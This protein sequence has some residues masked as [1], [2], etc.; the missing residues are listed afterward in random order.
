MQPQPYHFEVR[1]D[2]KTGTIKPWELW[3]VFDATGK[4]FA[5][6]GSFKTEAAAQKAADKANAARR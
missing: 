3:S 5:R 4:L 1:H 6:N 2:P